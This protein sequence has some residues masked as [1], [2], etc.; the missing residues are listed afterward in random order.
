MVSTHF[1]PYL[2][3]QRHDK[4][5]EGTER[6]G[7]DASAKEIE[8]VGAAGRNMTSFVFLDGIT[9][10][11]KWSVSIKGNKRIVSSDLSYHT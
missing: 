9:E 2:K 4:R 8:Q 3:L 5:R 11:K 6:F 10:R 1:W 7:T